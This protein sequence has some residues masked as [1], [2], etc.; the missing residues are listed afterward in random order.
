MFS[1]PSFKIGSE[2]K[3]VIFMS[4]SYE[5]EREREREGEWESISYPVLISVKWGLSELGQGL[6]LM[7]YLPKLADIKTWVHA[8]VL[9][10]HARNIVSSDLHF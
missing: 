7:H 8:F 1:P 4:L 6:T 9:S 3:L 2:T 10:N 5:R